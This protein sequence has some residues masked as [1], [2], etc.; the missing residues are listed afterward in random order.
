MVKHQETHPGLTVEGCYGCKIS[1]VRFGGM[2]RMA[3]EREGNYT[4][5]EIEKATIKE[6]ERSGTPI[7]RVNNRWI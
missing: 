4:Q 6:A 3:S 5:G 7:S 1:S 2:A